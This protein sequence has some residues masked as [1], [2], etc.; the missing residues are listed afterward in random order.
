MTFDLDKAATTVY[1]K[2]SDGTDT[3]LYN[4]TN[5]GGNSWSCTAAGQ[6]APIADA[7]SLQ[8]VAAQ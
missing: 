8:V 1:A 4:C 5:T 7:N 3:Y 6:E 2:I